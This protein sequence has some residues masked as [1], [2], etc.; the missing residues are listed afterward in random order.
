MNV[1]RED[2]DGRRAA[3]SIEVDEERVEAARRKAAARLGKQVRIPGFRPGKAPYNLVVQHIGP[4]QVL[5]EAIEIL[6]PEVIDEAVAEAEIEV[7]SFRD[8][9]IKLESTTPLV[10]H[11]TL[12]LV[13]EVRLGDPTAIEVD[14]LEVTVT[15]EDVD[16]VI[17]GI[18]ESRA[19]WEPISGP[20]AY[21][22]QISVDLR[23]DLMDGT[24]VLDETGTEMLLKNYEE[25]DEETDEAVDEQI[26]E[27]TEH[28]DDE[29]QPGDD[30]EL[31]DEELFDDDEELDDDEEEFGPPAPPMDDH[32]VGMMVN[33][34]KEF[35]LIYPEGFM[36]PRLSGRTVLVRATLMEAKRKSLPELDDEFARDVLA[37]FEVENVEQMRDKLRENLQEEREEQEYE[38]VVNAIIA[39]L[40]DEAELDYPDALVRA[41]VERRL[42]RM[43]QQIQSYGITMEKYYELTGSSREVL[44]GAQ[45]DDAED[46]V[47]R[48]LAIS[49]YVSQSE[50]ELSQDD[51]RKE[52]MLLSR[53]YDERSARDLIDQIQGDQEV[54]N[55]VAN[56]LLTRKAV[57]ALYLEVTGEEAPP[58]FPPALE[59]AVAAAEASEIEAEGAGDPAD[60]PA[61]LDADDSESAEDESAEDESGDES[62]AES[63]ESPLDEATTTDVNVDEAPADETPVDEAPVDETTDA[64]AAGTG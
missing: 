32:L 21:G 58:L 31:D 55:N 36:D 33:Q 57:R 47:R 59:E 50:L 38:R 3:L 44:E 40:A 56:G 22:D 34:V 53:G 13:P 52:I 2:L 63:A 28:L 30:A 45:W 6:L 18:R 51:L 23:G 20:V 60:A 24:T 39:K 29:E 62:G 7:Y 43:A 42:E 48:S 10:I 35:P 5:E 4:H 41:E 9:D 64:A 17:A 19:V 16:D 25:A 26:G 46:F 11:V 1:T 49:E 37:Q 14:R 27:A 54:L 12:P 61:A 15:E 8:A